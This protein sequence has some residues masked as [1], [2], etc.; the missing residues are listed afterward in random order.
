M[1]FQHEDTIS[2]MKLHN[3]WTS[4]SGTVQPNASTQCISICKRHTKQSIM[5]IWK[6]NS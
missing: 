1:S 5:I 6:R 3:Y 2:N 4:C